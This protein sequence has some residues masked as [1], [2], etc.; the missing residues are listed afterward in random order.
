M[1][2]ETKA[3]LLNLFRDYLCTEEQREIIKRQ[4]FEERQK[5]E[6]RKQMIYNSNDMFNKIDKEKKLIQEKSS[7][8]EFP[9]VE[10]KER[11]FIKIIKKM[12]EWLKMM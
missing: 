12:K 8:T 2:V 7:N 1:L 11:F 10:Y 4:Q 9:I 5:N 3:I 6:I